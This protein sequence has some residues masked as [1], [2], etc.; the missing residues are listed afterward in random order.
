M[1]RIAKM[2][3]SVVEGLTAAAV[4]PSPEDDDPLVMVDQAIDAMIA[5]VQIIDENIGKIKV[6]DVPQK[7]AVDA[8]RDLMDNA[9]APYLADVVKAMGVFAEPTQD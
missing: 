3:D 5:A 1:E 9:V 6:E 2:T 7:A 4:P 8:I